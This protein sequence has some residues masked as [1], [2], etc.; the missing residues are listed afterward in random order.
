MSFDVPARLFEVEL[1]QWGIV[2]TGAGDQYVRDYARIYGMKTSVQGFT[3][4]ASFLN[5]RW[6]GVTVTA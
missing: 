1:G 6:E 2:R 5:V 4:H 3:P